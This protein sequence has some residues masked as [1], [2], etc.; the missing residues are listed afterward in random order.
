MQTLKSTGLCLD[1]RAAPGNT[2]VDVSRYHHTI[3][4]NNV[5]TVKGMGDALGG[6]YDGATAY[7]DCGNHSSL[8]ITDAI[9]IE[10]W[11]KR[12]GK[13]SDASIDAIMGKGVAISYAIYMANI[14]FKYVFRITADADLS[15][16]ANI[17]LPLNEWEHWVSTYDG[18]YMKIY[19]NGVFHKEVSQVG[20]IGTGA[21][22]FQIGKIGNRPTYFFNGSIFLAR[23]YNRALPAYEIL[24]HYY[25]YAALLGLD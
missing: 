25:E 8:N 3:T 20:N 4:N 14:N 17:A 23:I 15:L 9:T 2:F 21:Y 24:D 22:N 1:V 11:V 6:G 19:R 5:V 12:E 16:T 10:A 7:L 18:S 13:G